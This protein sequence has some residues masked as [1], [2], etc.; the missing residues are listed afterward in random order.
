MMS[1]GWLLFRRFSHSR[2]IEGRLLAAAVAFERARLADRIGPLENPV[3]PGGQTREYFRFH[4]LRPG[5]TQIG[6]QS[7]QSVGGK[8]RPFLPQHADLVLPIDVIERGSD[9][10]Q[11]L[12]RPG[13]DHVADLSSR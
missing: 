1:M 11:M 9:E 8:T 5:E 13:I 6:F 12:R 4:G 3:L 7:G 10:T 2:R